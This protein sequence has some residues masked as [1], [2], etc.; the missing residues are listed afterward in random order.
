MSEAIKDIP[1]KKYPYE[2]FILAWDFTNDFETGE[3]IDLGNSTASAE[4]KNGNNVTSTLLDLTEL[5]SSGNKLIV[6]CRSGV[7]AS[8]PYYVSMKCQSTLGYKYQGVITI[9]I[10][11]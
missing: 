3:A 8:S 9:N 5:S 1:V 11:E 6:T 10:L 7:Y 2:R 4:D